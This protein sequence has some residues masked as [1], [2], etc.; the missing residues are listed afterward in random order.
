MKRKFMMFLISFVMCFSTFALSACGD[1]NTG[2]G[3]SQKTI[4]NSEYLEYSEAC[5]SIY[6]DIKNNSVLA[7]ESPN[8]AWM[9]N[10]YQIVSSAETEEY[11]E[12][13]DAMTR[14]IKSYLCVGLGAGDLITSKGNSSVFYNKVLEITYPQQ[15]STLFKINKSG[16]HLYVYV[17]DNSIS[18]MRVF[19]DFNIHENGGYDFVSVAISK[20]GNGIDVAIGDSQ[21]NFVEITKYYQNVRIIV[22]NG[23]TGYMSSD[24]SMLDNDVISEKFEESIELLESKKAVIN[25]LNSSID[26]SYDYDLVEETAKK[27]FSDSTDDG[28]DPDD[29]KSYTVKI[30]VDGEEYGTFDSDSESWIQKI[31]EL[32]NYYGEANLDGWYLDA[33]KSKKADL[34]NLGDIKENISLYAFTND[35]LSVVFVDESGNELARFT[36]SKGDK[37]ESIWDRIPSIPQKAG[38]VGK[39]LSEDTREEI[40]KDDDAG[41]NPCYSLYYIPIEYKVNYHDLTDEE[42]QNLRLPT[43]RTVCRDEELPNRQ[44][45]RSGYRFEGFYD[46]ME[47]GQK[48]NYIPAGMGEYDVYVRL[49]PIVY[50][51]R[52]DDLDGYETPSKTTYTVEDD[53]FNLQ[54]LADNVFQEFLGWKINGNGQYITSIN[55]SEFHENLNICAMWNYISYNIEVVD[56]NSKMYSCKYILTKG[57]VYKGD[58]QFDL[59]REKYF[60]EL[61]EPS[62]NTNIVGYKFEKWINVDSGASITEITEDNLIKGRTIRIK[63]IFSLVEYKITYADLYGTKVENPTTYNVEDTII[64]SSPIGNRVGYTFDY[65]TDSNGQLDRN[66]PI[67]DCTTGGD[68]TI[69]ANWKVNTYTIKLHLFEKTRSYD[70]KINNTY[71][72]SDAIDL[73]KYDITKCDYSLDINENNLLLDYKDNIELGHDFIFLGFKVNVDFDYSNNITTEEEFNNLS[74]NKEGEIV[75]NITSDM[76]GDIELWPVY[77]I[78]NYTVSYLNT[79]TNENAKVNDNLPTTINCLTPMFNLTDADTYSTDTRVGYTNSGWRIENGIYSYDYINGQT[80]DYSEDDIVTVKIV[81]RVVTYRVTYWKC[82]NY[83]N[84]LSNNKEYNNIG[85]Y[86]DVEDDEFMLDSPSSE[87]YGYNFVGWTTA[88][89]GAGEKITK[90]IPGENENE[91]HSNINVYDCWEEKDV[92][93]TYHYNDGGENEKTFTQTAEYHN[94]IIT[95]PIDMRIRDGYIFRGWREEKD[96]TI[97][98][99]SNSNEGTKY[100]FYNNEETYDLYAIWEL[101]IEYELQEDNTFKLTHL[102]IRD[103]SEWTI[104]QTATV[105]GVT[106]QVTAIGN[107]AF[108]YAI[109]SKL[110]MKDSNI[111][112]LENYAISV[113]LIDGLPNNLEKIGSCN[114]EGTKLI[115]GDKLVIP[116][117]LKTLGS[118]VFY[119]F[120]LE[121]DFSY[122]TFTEIGASVFSGYKYETLS[123]PDCVKKIDITAFNSPEYDLS[124]ITELKLPKDVEIIQSSND[125]KMDITKLTKLTSSSNILKYFKNYSATK[126][127]LKEIVLLDT[128][129]L[130]ND[131][132]EIGFFQAVEKVDLNKFTGIEIPSNAFKNLYLLDNINLPKTITKIGESAFANCYCLSN[133]TTIEQTRPL[134]NASIIDGYQV[135]LPDGILEIS[136]KAFANCVS[137]KGLR[138]GKSIE[139]IGEGAFSG[140]ASLETLRLQY[141]GKSKDS[142]NLETTA[143]NYNEAYMPW[144]FGTMIPEKHVINAGDKTVF[145]TKKVGDIAIKDIVT[146]MYAGDGHGATYFKYY[147]SDLRFILPVVFNFVTFESEI[148]SV[149]SYSLAISAKIEFEGGIKGAINSHGL[150]IVDWEEGT[151][152]YDFTNI[153][154][155]EDYALDFGGVHYKNARD[156]KLDA[157]K[158]VYIGDRAFNYYYGN[159]KFINSNKNSTHTIETGYRVNVVSETYSRI[160]SGWLSGYRGYYRGYSIDIPY[161]IDEFREG[162]LADCYVREITF[163][164]TTIVRNGSEIFKISTLV[165]N[166]NVL[167]KYITKI[168]FKSGIIQ[169]NLFYEIFGESETDNAK[170]NTERENNN[171]NGLEIVLG[172]DVTTILGSNA[173]QT[174]ANGYGVMIST[175]LKC[176][177]FEK[178]ENIKQLDAYIYDY[179]DK[180][181]LVLENHIYYL[182]TTAVGVNLTKADENSD[183]VVAVT[184]LTFREGTTVVGNLFA[185]AELSKTIKAIYLPGSVQNISICVFQDNFSATLNCLT[186]IYF[187]GT[188]TAWKA[189]MAKTFADE[190]YTEKDL[191]EISAITVQDKSIT[192]HYFENENDTTYTATHTYNRQNGSLK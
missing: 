95:T 65:W 15:D 184:T 106:A 192:L 131:W 50:N 41:L 137:I 93:I 110:Y 136:T 127:K 111:K 12:A 153:T 21:L 105:N 183:E 101:K 156:I 28:S 162:M 165:C 186:D 71:C 36:L 145:D 22:Y 37:I 35:N 82:S 126:A 64:F 24:I 87:N 159:I 138:V 78:K 84:N 100:N 190:K 66:N 109:I 169:S 172:E 83:W 58:F 52:Y 88:P 130:S 13:Q 116:S 85:R 39:F 1:G 164:R 173:F 176:I 94:F 124:N 45:I 125:D 46:Q 121:I 10:V 158:L 57:D 60:I 98:N 139:V 112:V 29:Q 143:E 68:R 170:M 20:D 179:L 42:V 81:W 62:I 56:Y 63:P 97:P 48:L 104:P 128:D 150:R 77:K 49:T 132:S 69:T 134:K 191:N 103:N 92:T 8:K 180:T 155:L 113:P 43:T 61:G 32:N 166:D 51:I 80:I 117:S 23:T 174:L 141:V 30:F 2:G 187:A 154:R 90:I 147:K 26:Y 91:Y 70:K 182:A 75:T 129:T 122:A 148:D 86:Y 135:D 76:I 7:C 3:D 6:N 102:R 149:A 11:V 161:E 114:L 107:S 168:T 119:N 144:V 53:I 27:Y 4:V 16:S 40:S 59:N 120:N 79:A 108:D 140:C 189:I 33:N 74:L 175:G 181:Q 18:N 38:F 178:P 72:Y 152:P 123:I 151:L 73:G 99:Y 67:L 171:A 133:L 118:Y 9:Q 89:N 115:N 96:A 157:S 31:E 47:G 5:T 167:R 146:Y 55:P 34:K 188:K 54:P 163:P 44:F 185:S 177:T 142:K 17:D 25:S 19:A 14:I 160:V